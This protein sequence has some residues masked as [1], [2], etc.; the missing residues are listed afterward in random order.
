[1]KSALK[2]LLEAS[3]ESFITEACEKD[4]WPQEG[5]AHDELGEHM[6]NAAE[7]V[8]DASYASSVYTSKEI[9]S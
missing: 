6:A 5:L 8:F 2:A 9:Q 7:A 4:I 1:M 3:I